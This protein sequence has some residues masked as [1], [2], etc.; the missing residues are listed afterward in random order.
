MTDNEQKFFD[1]FFQ[2]IDSVDA[3]TTE[4]IFELLWQI[5]AKSEK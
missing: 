3:E 4:I 2:N 5:I 1:T